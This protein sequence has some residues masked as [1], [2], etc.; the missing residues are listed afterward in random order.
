MA[1]SLYTTQPIEVAAEK[2]TGGPMKLVQIITITTNYDSSGNVISTVATVSSVANPGSGF[3]M[4]LNDWVV[5]SGTTE[6][7]YPDAQFQSLFVAVPGGTP[8]VVAV[9]YALPGDPMSAG[10][11]IV[12]SG[13]VSHGARVDWGDGQVDNLTGL[14][15]TTP[16]SDQHTYTMATAYT[17]TVSLWG[18][19]G[20]SGAPAATDQMQ[21]VA[22]TVDLSTVDASVNFGDS[23]VVVG[24][25]MQ[26]ADGAA[27]ASLFTPLPGYTGSEVTP[28]ENA[29]GGGIDVL[30]KQSTVGE[31]TPE[32][33]ADW[34][35][36]RNQPPPFAE[37]EQPWAP[38]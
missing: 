27:E 15:T 12:F 23:G 13:D 37:Q 2:F 32:E 11:Q 4:N 35:G 17:I 31:M 10:L 7:V 34:L 29:E 19:S 18:A 26:S 38:G 24:A 36:Q 21:F 14:S 16:T 30:S 9:L 5:Q 33:M 22:S 28:G 25:T 8:G 20:S 1:Y 6:A 3:S